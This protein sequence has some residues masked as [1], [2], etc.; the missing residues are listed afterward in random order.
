MWFDYCAGIRDSRTGSDG[1]G[2]RDLNLDL[3]TSFI[4]VMPYY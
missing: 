2:Y 1:G 3:E 4:L